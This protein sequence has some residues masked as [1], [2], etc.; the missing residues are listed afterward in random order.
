MVDFLAYQIS[1]IGQCGEFSMVYLAT[2]LTTLLPVSGI[3][4]ICFQ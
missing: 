3:H 2:Y 4:G 1:L